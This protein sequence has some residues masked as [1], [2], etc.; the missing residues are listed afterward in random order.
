MA[1]SDGP[2]PGEKKSRK[3]E[4]QKLGVTTGTSETGEVFTFFYGTDTPFSQFH[5]AKFVVDGQEYNCAEQYMMH[6]KA[7]GWVGG[8]G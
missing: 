3:K 7:G 8:W 1:T 2:A 4:H 5:P 6:Q